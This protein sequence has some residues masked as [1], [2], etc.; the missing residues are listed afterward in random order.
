MDFWEWLRQQLKRPPEEIGTRP[1]PTVE[2][3]KTPFVQDTLYPLIG[4]RPNAVVNAPF[5]PQ[6]P[7]ARGAAFPAGRW[8]A[9]AQPRD[10]KGD[11][12]A[13]FH[14]MGHIADLRNAIPELDDITEMYFPVQQQM[15][16]EAY[17]SKNKREYQATVFTQAL[18]RVRRLNR[19]AETFQDP[20]FA[21][22]E[23]QS[24]L[25]EE[26]RRLPGI[27][28]ATYVLLRQPVFANTPAGSLYRHQ[29]SS[30]PMSGPSPR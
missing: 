12:E 29:M 21:L 7:T 15:F 1:N 20:D 23:L 4:G 14:E 24:S 17:A 27:G 26:E 22:R 16:P 6:A 2:L 30:R 11:V 8:V 13:V 9:F 10:G 18:E 28:A 19:M 5:I 25:P 3:L